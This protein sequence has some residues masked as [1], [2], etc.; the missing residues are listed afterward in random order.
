MRSAVDSEQL[1]MATRAG[2]VVFTQDVDFLRL[3][4]T[5]EPQAGIVF[6]QQ[7][8]AIGHIVRELLLIYQTLSAEEMENRVEFL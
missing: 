7:G 6:A 8:T 5:G 4:S 1:D 3:H 2:R